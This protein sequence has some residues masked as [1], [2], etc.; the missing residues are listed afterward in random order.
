LCTDAGSTGKVDVYYFDTFDDAQN[1]PLLK[2]V[3]QVL[4][5][6]GHVTKNDGRGRLWILESVD[7]D[8]GYKNKADSLFINR[9]ISSMEKQP[10]EIIMIAGSEVAPPETVEMSGQIANRADF[11]RVWAWAQATGRVVTEA[12]WSANPGC[13]SS[14][15]LS[16][17]FRFPDASKGFIR[18]KAAAGTLGLYVA[19]TNQ[20]HTHTGS[21]ATAGNHTHTVA[22]GGDGSATGT[23]QRSANTFYNASTSAAGDHTH[24]ITIGSTG[25]TEAAPKHIYESFFI[26]I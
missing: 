17:T 9:L 5:T 20:A 23:I 24:T 8:F 21:S 10:G 22:V 25:G 7:K 13:F 3:G 15:D 14:G 4:Y 2:D 6:F 12:E 26:K 19:D 18:P 11:K 1:S 16:T